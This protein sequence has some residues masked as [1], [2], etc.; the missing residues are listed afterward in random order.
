MQGVIVF[1][2]LFLVIGIPWIILEVGGTWSIEKL[3]GLEKKW[4]ADTSGRYRKSL[5]VLR[6]LGLLVTLLA[7][8]FLVYGLAGEL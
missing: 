8:A 3:I 5:L 4:E 7:L 1:A 6:A 2:V